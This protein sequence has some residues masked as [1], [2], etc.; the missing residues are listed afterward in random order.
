MCHPGSSNKT[1]PL[2]S[3]TPCELLGAKYIQ[4]ATH[5][6]T[7]VY[8]ATLIFTSNAAFRCLLISPRMPFYKMLVLGTEW[9][10]WAAGLPPC[11]LGPQTHKSQLHTPATSQLASGHSLFCFWLLSFS[12]PTSSSLFINFWATHVTSSCFFFY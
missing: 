5:V 10:V 6:E 7:K 2:N 4:T 8:K 3:A 12:M 11:S 1:T 9:A